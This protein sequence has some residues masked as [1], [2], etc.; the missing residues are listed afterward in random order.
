MIFDKRLSK[1][2]GL[3]ALAGALAGSAAVAGAIY[4]SRYRKPKDGKAGALT[5]TRP[6]KEL[7]GSPEQ[8]GVSAESLKASEVSATK[9]PNAQ[10]P[11]DT[12]MSLLAFIFRD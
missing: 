3:G 10:S 2:C 11:N 6:D 1:W 5:A 9:L 12:R 8:S 4:A 7:P